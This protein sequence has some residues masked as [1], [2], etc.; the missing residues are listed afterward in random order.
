MRF[1]TPLALAVCLLAPLSPAHA[2]SILLAPS[3]TPGIEVQ[4]RLVGLGHTVTVGNPASW[5]AGFDYAPYDVVVFQFSSNDP[6]DIAHLVAAV[7]AS[8]VGVVFFRGFGTENTALALGLISGGQ[9]NWQSRTDLNVT[10]NTHALTAGLS[11]GVQNLGYNF[12]SWVEVPAGATTTTLATGPGG[13]ALVVHNTRR[14]VITP[15]YAHD[16]GY[17]DENATGLDVT[18]RSI[19]WAAGDQATPVAT[20]SWGRIKATYR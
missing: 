7:D 1:A 9:L 15:F 11:L 10:N 13:A 18:Q 4:A 20:S 5:G 14:A 17:A 2:A 3:G 12:M 19:L 8:Q 6:A 16:S